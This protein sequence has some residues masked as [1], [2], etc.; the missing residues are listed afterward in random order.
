MK[1][2]IVVIGASVGGVT[3]LL[4]LA[5][6]LPPQFP[7][8]VF[9]VLHVGAHASQLPILLSARGPNPA[10]HPSSGA[11]IVSG[12]LYVAP[13]DFHMLV[14]RNQICLVSGPKEHH[15]RPAVDPL[16][17]SAAL[18]FGPRVIG[19]VLTGRFNDGTAGLQAIKQCG[20]L[21]MVQ[22]PDEAEEPSMPASA[23]KHVKVDYRFSINELG[24]GLVD[25][26]GEPMSDVHKRGSE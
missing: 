10:I 4:Q 15:T 16:F 13:P 20:G 14:E 17:R 24:R 18:A 22:D 26:L 7:A 6:T 3:A 5:S 11:P 9:I 23:L 1:R 12:T 25:I 2:D 21:A 8:A 19:I